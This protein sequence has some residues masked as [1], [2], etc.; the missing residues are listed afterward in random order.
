MKAISSLFVAL[1]G[2]T[3]ALMAGS[4]AEQ[5][6]SVAL[7]LAIDASGTVDS[8]EFDLQ[9]RGLMEAFRHPDVIAAIEA[10]GGIAVAV[11]QWSGRGQQVV[12]VDWTQ[13]ADEVSSSALAARIQASGRRLIG[14]TTVIDR[15][16]L[17]CVQLLGNS[18]FQ[19]DRKV[20]DLS[21]DGKTNYGPPPD[22]ARNRAV[23]AG[24]TINGL[25]ILNEAA[26]LAEYYRKHV[27][28][29]PGSFLMTARDYR[30]F[31]TAIRLKLIREILYSAVAARPPATTGR[32]ART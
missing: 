23:A 2:L 7:V 22:M 9:A 15:A 20:I 6:V 32:T 16:L 12:A 30:D 25:A 11:V 5:R 26:D 10:T 4:S 1:C 13:V 27:V 29:G 21:G 17:F 28:G 18:P 31:A 3:F 19:S 14:G 24:I 8:E